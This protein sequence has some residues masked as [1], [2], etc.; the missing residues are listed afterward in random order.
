MTLSAPTVYWTFL[1]QL[2]RRF[3]LILFC[4]SCSDAQA[5]KDSLFEQSKAL[6]ELV[7]ASGLV[8][9]PCALLCCTYNAHFACV[10]LQKKDKRGA[11]S[12]VGTAC[13]FGLGIVFA[14]ILACVAVRAN[15]PHDL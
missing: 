12:K 1:L 10:N 4:F 3:I 5:D 14:L 2:A 9:P 15:G 6:L 11:C 8:R 7:K 13:S